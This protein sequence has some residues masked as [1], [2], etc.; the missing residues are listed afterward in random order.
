MS[1]RPA[2]F[3][4]ESGPQFVSADTL[5]ARAL[6]QEAANANSIAQRAHIGASYTKAANA[7]S[8]PQRAHIGASNTD[9]IHKCSWVV[10]V[11]GSVS[12]KDCDKGKVKKVS[13]KGKKHRKPSKSY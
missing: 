5:L 6:E 7:Y 2:N 4:E 13:H 12:C 3:L 11:D 1:R 9:D 8:I 10:D